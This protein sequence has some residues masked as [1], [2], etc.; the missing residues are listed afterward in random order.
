MKTLIELQK[1]FGARALT[2]HTGVAGLRGGMHFE[3]RDVTDANGAFEL[4]FIGSDN[5]LDRYNE[6]IDPCAWGDMKNFKANPVIPDCHD[7]SSVVKILG[8]AK[9]VEVRDGKLFNRVEFAMDNP[10]GVM[11]YKMAKGRF[12]NSQSVGFIPLTWANG[13]QAGQP[14]RTYTKCELL[15]ISLVVVP[16]NPG[17]TVGLALKSGALQRSDVLAAAKFLAGLAGKEFSNDKQDSS[18]TGGASA[19]GSDYAQLLESAKWM[20]L[21]R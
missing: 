1:D 2:L 15:E 21:L 17:A 20:R 10:L 7:Y 6:V 3:I 18:G 11:A 19:A 9:T 5:S 4:D 8:R 16:A 12:I 14:D 13:S